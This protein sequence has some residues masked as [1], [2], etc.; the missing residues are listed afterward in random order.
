MTVSIDEDNESIQKVENKV[1][2]WIENTGFELDKN[3]SVMFNMPYLYE[4]GR[5]IIYKDIEK[6]L[7]YKQMQRYY[8][9]KLRDNM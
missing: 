4:N 8:P 1:Q 2:R 3:R 9:I 5:D 7:G 6:G